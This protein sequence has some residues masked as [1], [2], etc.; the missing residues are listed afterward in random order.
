[1][2]G[3]QFQLRTRWLVAVTL[4]VS[5]VAVAITR[6][7][8]HGLADESPVDTSDAPIQLSADWSQEWREAGTTISIF[9]G[10]CR[11][12]HG[13]QTYTANSMVVW[14][15]DRANRS[16]QRHH[17]R[18]Y[19]ENGVQIQTPT[20]IRN[21]QAHWVDLTS[22][23]GVSLTV[24]GRVASRPGVDD[25][26]Y[27][28]AVERPG[29]TRTQ[30]NQTQLTVA[31]P[32]PQVVDPSWRTVQLD[33]LAGLRRVRISPRSISMPF[34][35]HGYT[36]NET[37]PPEQI[38]LITGGVNIV[39]DGMTIGGEE[40]MGAVDL[41]ADRVI[42]WTEAAEGGQFSPE[43]LQ[44]P[45]QSF[46]L[47]LEGNIVIRRQSVLPVMGNPEVSNVIRATRA[48]YDARENRALILNAEMQAYI[49]SMDASFRIRADR[50]RQNSLKSYHAQNAWFTTSQMG[51]PG[52]RLQAQDLFL[53][54][55]PSNTMV[56]DPE[57]GQAVPR[58]TY[59]VT[60]QD[61]TFV[62]EGVPLLYVPRMST[63]VEDPGVP[64][65]GLNLGQDRIFGTQVRTRWDAFSTFGIQR[66]E[67]VDARWNLLLDYLSYR[68]LAVGTDGKYSG[69]DP[70]GN[71]FVGNG[72]AYYAHDGGVDNLGRDRM[73]LE[74]SDPNRGLLQWQHSHVFQP[75]NMKLL[76]EV[77]V[78]SDRNFRESY[79]EKD[80]DSGKDLDTLAYLRQQPDENW[81]W[82]LLAQPTINRF[83][84]NTAWLPRGDLN[85]LGVP[86][87]G[88]W[89][90]WSQHT[91]L[92]YAALNQ[93]Q[94]PTNPM[95]TFSPLPY[96]TDAS[97]LV[98]MTRHE[99]TAPFNLGPIKLAPYLMG[100][101]AY[102]S[103]S[104]TNQSID[105]LYGRGGLRANI[106]FWRAYPQVQSDLLNL[107]GLAHKIS[108]DADYGY[109]QSS[110]SLS[111]IPQWNQFE[112]NAQE[113]FRERFLTNTFGGTL[114]PQFD[115]RF[116]AVRSQAAT[117]VSAQYNELVDS[118]QAL[119][120]G[121]SQRLQTKV[122]P[123]D[124]QRIKDWMT[125]DLG[126]SYFPNPNRD[127]FG[128]NFG[129]FNAHYSWNV[130]DR[131]TLI[132]DSM[133]DFFNNGQ[134]WWN[135][136]VMTQRS[137]RGS[138]YVGIQQIK[139]A[140]LDSQIL[141]GSYSY[142]MS[143][144]W[145]STM[146]ASYDL[147]QNQSRGQ[148]IT[149]TRIGE[150][151]LFHFGANYDWSKNNAGFLFSVEPKLGR[152]NSATQLGTLGSIPTAQ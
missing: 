150:W 51:E 94:A 52:Y 57:T 112:D 14:A 38:T 104:F 119:R 95:D 114:P 113:R 138:A 93:A 125:L 34:N 151:M 30:L 141:T 37:T 67:G 45:E 101:A 40:G 97:G 123:P 146:S 79:F 35:I 36:S 77:G 59:W 27:R 136:G 92:G 5:A 12:I 124:R 137:F 144:K 50:I 142:A 107:N 58:D 68:G 16:D 73:A 48:F 86:L 111:E 83:E 98:T 134:Q 127:N 42:I 15:H 19:L 117:S 103:D 66:P 28:R 78:A 147:A 152:S 109:A 8:V 18:I 90:N 9:R 71:P 61:T 88:G 105:R 110:R 44:R 69:T 33:P 115:P 145:V 130:G 80:F 132:A 129:L 24:K 10:S 60:A 82:S 149:I 148:S 74:P 46:Q 72:L 41:S 63:P 84:N 2:R 11:V 6:P 76:T 108:V 21:E 62:V 131:T 29:T 3:S 91:S 20:G 64:L 22:S 55:R 106:Q 53:E 23:R 7:H 89:L 56:V 87:L 135:I 49:P 118:Q 70:Y 128:E 47:Y 121:L 25:P 143:P 139:G 85:T 4:A 99:L 39:V 122:G 32:A 75:Y 133:Y 140:T 26:L 116:Y 1:M 102:W 96:F 13:G 17:L 81:T 126:V 100:E 65:V 43:M 120:L 31:A 54:S